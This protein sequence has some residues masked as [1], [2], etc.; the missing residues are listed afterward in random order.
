MLPLPIWR[1][2]AWALVLILFVHLVQAQTPDWEWAQDAAGDKAASYGI[3]H[4]ADGSYSVAGNFQHTLAF[5]NYTLTSNGGDDVFVAHYTAQGQIGWSIQAGGPGNDGALAVATDAAG[6][7]VVTGRF[8]GVANFGP[9]QLTSVGDDDFFLAKYMAAGVLLWVRQAGGPL[10]DVG[11][12]LAIDGSGS[13]LVTGTFKG[14]L[15]LDATTLTSA[16]ETA[17]LAKFD[18]QGNTVWMQ[19]IIDGQAAGL[20]VDSGG[21]V[22]LAGAFTAGRRLLAKYSGNTGALLVTSVLAGRGAHIGNAV[23]I[24]PDG[25]V[26]VTGSFQDTL[27]LGSDRLISQG[28]GNGFLAKFTPQGV[29]VWGQNV[30]GR[31]ADQSYSVAVSAADNIA[32][33]GYF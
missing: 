16:N 23:A 28:T 13:I 17:F 6:N 14:T 27:Q 10:A 30:G 22:Y 19:A 21:N 26:Y 15:T 12:A 29:A 7:V 31:Q 5:G 4:H 1:S 2:G 11:R 20:A 9:T 33:T 32:I 24:G 3:V 8:R 18:S 25:S